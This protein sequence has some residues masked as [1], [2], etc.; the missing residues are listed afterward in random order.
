M[1]E[2]ITEILLRSDGTVFVHNLTPAL[3]KL[4]TELDPENEEMRQR[5]QPQLAAQSN[6]ATS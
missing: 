3:A 6:D 5:A 1:N 4:L 2:Q